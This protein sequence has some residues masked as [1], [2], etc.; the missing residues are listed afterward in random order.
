[1]V[2][3][4]GLLLL[5]ANASVAAAPDGAELYGRHCAACHGTGGR[6][7]VGTP[8]ALHDF[9]ASVS[10]SYLRKTILAGRPGR[11]MPGH[12]FLS[13]AEVDAVVTHMRG[14]MAP[15]T[16][17]PAEDPVP[18]TGDRVR[19]QAL[20]AEHCESCHGP[21]GQG[22]AG[23]G[24]TFSRPRDLPIIAPA[25]GN[26]AFLDAASD[27]MIKRT[28]IQGRRG[29]PMISFIAKGLTERDIDDVVAYLRSLRDEPAAWQVDEGQEPYLVYTSAYG[30]DET[31][32]N[33]KRAAIGKNFRIIRQQNLEEGMF[34]PDQENSAQRIVYFCNFNLIND[35]M[36]IDPRVGMFMPCRVTVVEQDGVV[37]LMSL[38]PKFLGRFFN[39]IQ[40]DEPCTQMYRTYVEIME[41]ATL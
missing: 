11:V 22:G 15:G 31:V 40:L 28:L 26:P 39:N 19:G 33:L 8:L 25:I 2:R 14:W 20:F 13:A 17:I 34:P 27:S 6:G 29:T 18:V 10:D 9:L 12:D 7:G 24:V 37:K 23:T 38:N 1:M 32:E 4:L 5:F 3:L 21:K 30:M 36:K 41:E 35:A 16:A